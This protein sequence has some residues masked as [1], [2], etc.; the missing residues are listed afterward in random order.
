MKYLKFLYGLL[1]IL[2]FLSCNKAV[3]DRPPLT[4][5]VDADYWRNEDDVRL[6]ANAYYP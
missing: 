2:F 5:I 6:Y 1:A 3:L 4:T